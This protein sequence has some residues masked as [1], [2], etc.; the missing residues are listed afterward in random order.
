MRSLGLFCFPVAP[1]FALLCE[2]VACG[3]AFSA[4]PGDG[5]ADGSKT[6]DGNPATEGGLP[7]AEDAP[8]TDACKPESCGTCNHTCSFGST[9]NEA[10][11]CTLPSIA[12]EL[13]NPSG[14]A[15]SLDGTVF[16]GVNGACSSVDPAGRID[17]YSSKGLVA[18]INSIPCDQTTG[19]MLALNTHGMFWATSTAIGFSARVD[20]GP[21]VS[22]KTVPPVGT[23][24]VAFTVD[25]T[26]AFIAVNTGSIY[27]ERTSDLSSAAPKWTSLTLNA[28]AN[29]GAIALGP[30]DEALFFA[31]QCQGT[32]AMGSTNGFIASISIG[33]TSTL[34][35]GPKDE[36]TPTGLA[37]SLDRVYWVD[38]SMAIRSA[39]LTLTS[40]EVETSL[41]STARRIVGRGNGKIAW[42]DE[43]GN[44]LFH[45]E[46]G[47][48][49]GVLATGQDGAL[50]I[51][52]TST[53]VYWVRSGPSGSVDTAPW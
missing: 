17:E 16:V 14:L 42:T 30:T 24:V 53:Q 35:T 51:A 19:I 7:E 10:G 23:T 36:N 39:N 2:V 40:S 52:A 31:D 27:Y 15:V 49:N 45:E 28:N 38:S 41:T 34:D 12:S 8:I 5:S 21:T 29:V 4:G 11:L 33:S 9:C 37:V 13:D 26:N 25:E 3:Q 22:G 6:G 47:K 20:G 32:C 50:A 18:T 46:G 44:V 1:I 43:G 48:S